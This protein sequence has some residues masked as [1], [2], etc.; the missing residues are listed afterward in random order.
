MSA[1]YQRWARLLLAARAWA[2]TEVA[3]TDAESINSL[4]PRLHWR[5]GSSHFNRGLALAWVL[6]RTFKT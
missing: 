3:F 1:P 6:E 2:K 5:G 4:H